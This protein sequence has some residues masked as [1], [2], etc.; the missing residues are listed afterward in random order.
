MGLECVLRGRA[1]AFVVMT[2]ATDV[3]SAK[4]TFCQRCHRI[5]AEGL[6]DYFCGQNSSFA[7]DDLRRLN[8]RDSEL[9]QRKA[10]QE[11][12][13]KESALEMEVF[14]TRFGTGLLSV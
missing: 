5:C 14:E 6:R 7:E 11:L 12:E 4:A 13:A 3:L 2:T 1:M 9:I 8:L 10:K